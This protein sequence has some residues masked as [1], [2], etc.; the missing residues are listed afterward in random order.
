MGPR[1]RGQQPLL[2][3]PPVGQGRREAVTTTVGTADLYR[4]MLDRGRETTLLEGTDLAP[5]LRT[6]TDPS[7]SGN[8]RFVSLWT[9]RQGPHQAADQPEGHMAW[10]QPGCP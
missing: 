5:L 10:P 1:A 6:T 2:A 4:G 3:D 8:A 7:Y 9:P